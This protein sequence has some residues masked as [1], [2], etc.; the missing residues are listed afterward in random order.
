M[1]GSVSVS[2]NA[3]DFKSQKSTSICVFELDKIAS[4]KGIDLNEE[5]S[6]KNFLVQ[7][8]KVI[9]QIMLEK[10]C[11]LVYPAESTLYYDNNVDITNNIA[12][13]IE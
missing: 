4:Q 1:G 11:N 10:G 13:E 7:I 6:K 9:T 3:S 12:A 8:K 5:S 2:L